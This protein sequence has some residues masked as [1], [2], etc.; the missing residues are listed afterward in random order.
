MKKSKRYSAILVAAL[1][2]TTPI[3]MS[4]KVDASSRVDPIPS[5]S[6]SS[7]SGNLTDDSHS[8]HNEND[9]HKDRGNNPGGTNPGDPDKNKNAQ[10]GQ[11]IENPILVTYKYSDNLKTNI[12]ADKNLKV[13]DIAS[14]VGKNSF[15]YAHNN[16]KD[17]EKVGN[18]VGYNVT[19][20][21]GKYINLDK[22]H[23][24]PVLQEGDKIKI[25]GTTSNGLKPNTWYQWETDHYPSIPSE[26]NKNIP[27]DIKDRYQVK[28]LKNGKYQVTEKTDDK[29]SLISITI[30]KETA[31]KFGEVAGI[32]IEM[33]WVELNIKSASDK[34]AVSIP[35][36]DKKPTDRLL[37]GEVSS[38]SSSVDDKVDNPTPDIADTTSD[39]DTTTDVTQNPTPEPDQSNK[40]QGNKQKEDDK[41]DTTTPTSTVKLPLALSHNSYIYDENGKVQK[42]KNG[43]PIVLK[44]S[45]D[46]ST[47][48]NGKV[49]VINGKKFYQI[50]KNQYVKVANTTLP[51]MFTHNAYIYD[52]NGNAYKNKNGNYRVLRK[53]RNL[54]PL[55][56][57]K[58]VTIKGKKFYQIGKNQYV[59]VANTGNRPVAKTF[60]KAGTVKG[61]KKVRLYS[62]TGKYL[63]K[64]VSGK[65]SLK[66]SHVKTIKGKK[67]YQ[68]K[69]TKLWIRASKITVKK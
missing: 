55:N 19:D 15:I 8:S 68:I 31:D 17:I 23:D 69:G 25:M 12:K 26:D 32:D 10:L 7:K 35:I 30:H 60:K 22:G 46:I 20:K 66:F 24:N 57:G 48:N 1:L 28:N 59:K 40:G 3:L 4:N 41:A 65:K 49:T 58:I 21:S 27:T 56:N 6:N 39:D 52:K 47:L 18:T 64:Y 54:A 51:L 43:N 63:K 34:D 9:N 44:K 42:D 45:S 2:A 11:S 62:S 14:Y 61:T 29:G 36:S 37:K 50:G 5:T 67:Y 38:D 13:S 16:D 53:Y 33:P